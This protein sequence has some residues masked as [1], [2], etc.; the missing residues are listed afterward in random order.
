ME[1]SFHL[2]NIIELTVYHTVFFISGGVVDEVWMR[3]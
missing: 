3:L 1:V 2:D